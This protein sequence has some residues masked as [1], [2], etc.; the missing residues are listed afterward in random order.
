MDNIKIPSKQTRLT[1][2]TQKIKSNIFTATQNASTKHSCL[3][4]KNGCRAGYSKA[5]ELR[6]FYVIR[7]LISTRLFII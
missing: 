7:I 5:K 3:Y 4:C 1:R 2:N 6:N